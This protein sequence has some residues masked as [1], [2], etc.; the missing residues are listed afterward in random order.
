MNTGLPFRAECNKE[1]SYKTSPPYA[2]MPLT[3]VDYLFFAC[4]FQARCYIYF[5]STPEK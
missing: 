5:N 4:Y 3:E 1:C 2:L